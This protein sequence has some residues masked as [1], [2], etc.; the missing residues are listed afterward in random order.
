MKILVMGKSGQFARSLAE[1]A[2][3]RRRYR[4]GRD[5]AVRRSI[6]AFPGRPETLFWSDV[7]TSLSM[8]PPIPLSIG[9]ED[10]RCHAFRL[11]AEG[12]GEVA[13]AAAA[14]GRAV[15]HIS[16]DYVFDGS[17]SGRLTKPRR[18]RPLAPTAASQAGGEEAV[19]AANP[20]ASDRS[21]G[22]GVQSVWPQF[23][24]HDVRCRRRHATSCASST[25]S[26][27]TRPARSISPTRC[28]PRTGGTGGAGGAKPS[29]SPG[30]AKR[31]GPSLADA[32]MECR[33][34]S[35]FARRR[36]V[37]ISPVIGRHAPSVRQILS[38]QW[39]I[40]SMTSAV[41]MPDW[42][43]PSPRSSRGWRGPS[44]SGNPVHQL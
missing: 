15:I 21:H 33:D 18:P 12:A 5:W 41:R 38:R 22:L 2:G 35:A 42:R 6:W 29:I 7:P 37:P 40:R 24:A 4:V 27:A 31:V 10:D 13:A 3:N 30:P 20:E 11:N 36:L 32:V 16:T 25:I 17:A 19:R 23:R 43:D 8:P 39:Q 34:G 1:R 14:V 28:S 44:E 26:A 9:A